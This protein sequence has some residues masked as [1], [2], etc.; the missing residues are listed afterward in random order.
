MSKIEI[1]PNMTMEEKNLQIV[2]RIRKIT[3]S[4]LRAF[5]VIMNLVTDKLADGESHED[6]FNYIIYLD[7]SLDNFIEH[8]NAKHGR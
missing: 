1:T 7:T 3:D 5:T 2:R 4:D 6:V 8:L